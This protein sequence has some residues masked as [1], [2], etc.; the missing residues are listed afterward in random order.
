MRTID[1]IV[2]FVLSCGRYKVTLEK[3]LTAINEHAAANESVRMYQWMEDRWYIEV[4]N[5]IMHQKATDS[6]GRIRA[7]RFGLTVNVNTGHV[8]WNAQGGNCWVR[9]QKWL[10]FFKA[11]FP[12]Q[13]A[14]NARI[15]LERGRRQLEHKHVHLY[16]YRRAA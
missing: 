8:L 12:D 14:D 9:G 2:A 4:R 13:H 15:D 11:Q 5:D 3:L 10:R 1:P 7:M 16:G 6:D